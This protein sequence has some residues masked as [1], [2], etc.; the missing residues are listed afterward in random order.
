LQSRWLQ[1]RS[2]RAS[3]GP[4]GGGGGAKPAQPD[5]RAL[6]TV[7]V[8]AADGQTVTGRLDHI[9]DFSVSLRDSNNQFHSFT[10]DGAT[11]KVE[12]KDPLQAHTEL[13]RHYTDADIHNMTAY[14]VTLK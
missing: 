8:T 2:T 1:P 5:T 11:P 4:R 12:V 7:S 3:G 9:D 10:R 13:L 6:P 14:L